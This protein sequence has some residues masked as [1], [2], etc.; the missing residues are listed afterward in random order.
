M[1]NIPK[2]QQEYFNEIK[3]A[4]GIDDTEYLESLVRNKNAYGIRDELGT[5]LGQHVAEN[6]DT[7]LNVF[8][9]K[10]LLKDVPVKYEKMSGKA[11]YYTPKTNTITLQP[12]DLSKL[13]KQMGTKIHEFGHANDR[14]KGFP[15]VPV[16]ESSMK[17]LGLDAAEIALSPHHKSGF[18]ELEALKDLLK[19]KKIAGLALPLLKAAGVGALGASA[20][21]IGQKA[22]AGDFG[23]AA[24]DTADLATD[25][26]PVLGEVKAAINPTMMGNAELPQEEMEKR[27]RF[28]ELRKK[29]GM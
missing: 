10:E 27:N 1:G 22:M 17:K 2:K 20:L 13:E 15:S 12:E 11:G 16:N 26:T 3:K 25:L 4:L 24:S 5:I 28:N 14:L 6:Y 8:E 21:G 18:F 7:P 29:V 23:E 9:Q 19:N